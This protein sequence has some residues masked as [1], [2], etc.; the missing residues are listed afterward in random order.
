MHL[1]TIQRLGEVAI[2]LMGIWFA[3][4]ALVMVGTFLSLN[5]EPNF[6]PVS[7]AQFLPLGVHFF[8]GAFLLL[9]RHRLARLDVLLRFYRQD[10]NVAVFDEFTI[11]VGHGDVETI[12]EQLPSAFVRVG[13][14]DAIV[15]QQRV[16]HDRVDDA[17]RRVPRANHSDF[18]WS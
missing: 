8:A 3:V 17:L 6:P 15:K 2:S 16:A 10:D 13:R 4:Q 11:V 7:I 18:V 1:P 14:D 9:F 12:G 5:F